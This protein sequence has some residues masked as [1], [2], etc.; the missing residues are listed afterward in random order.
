M[1]DGFIDLITSLGVPPGV[2]SSATTWLLEVG[3]PPELLAASAGWAVVARKI[4]WP[5]VKMRR[6][7]D[8][9]GEGKGR[10]YIRRDLHGPVVALLSSLAGAGVAL[11]ASDPI[12]HGVGSGLL[13]ALASM[14]WHDVKGARGGRS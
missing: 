4:V 9:G 5:L 10:P 1:S 13:G 7:A 11:A 8:A 12:G 3:L 6:E 2:A 14:L